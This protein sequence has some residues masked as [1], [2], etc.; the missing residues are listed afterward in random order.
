M[1]SK[2]YLVLLVALVAVFFFSHFFYG[3]AAECASD[4]CANFNT[5][6]LPLIKT[7]PQQDQQFQLVAAGMRRKSLF[8]MEVDVYKVGI[9][10]SAMKDSA[11]QQ[12]KI[13]SGTLTT[14]LHKEY[15]ESSASLGIVLKF[16]RSV[17][18]DKIVGAM[19]EAFE[20]PSL[21][22]QDDNRRAYANS[23]R[24]FNKM[25]EKLMK[26]NNGAKTDDEILFT[27]CGEESDAIGV[28]LNEVFAGV[29]RNSELRHRLV[30]IYAGEKGVTKEIR[31]IL[32]ERYL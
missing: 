10:T 25:L 16:V 23:V 2:E 13:T 21:D 28:S 15:D 30:D 24:D 4:Y 12:M 27:F 19:Q 32:E 9:Y 3:N 14:S 11:L 31:H 18:S 17:G 26:P 20:P 6:G 8:I 22:D 1:A 7:F 5:Q 29:I